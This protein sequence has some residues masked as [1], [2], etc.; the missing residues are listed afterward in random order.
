M[1]NVLPQ[2]CRNLGFSVFISFL[3]FVKN[4]E[5]WTAGRRIKNLEMS[6]WT[7][8]DYGGHLVPFSNFSLTK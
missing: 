3:V 2:T 5:F 6:P 1:L 4:L 7:L 8:A